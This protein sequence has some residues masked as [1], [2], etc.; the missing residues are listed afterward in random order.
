MAKELF[1]VS[2]CDYPGCKEAFI[3]EHGVGIAQDTSAVSFW[4]YVHGKGRKTNPVIVDMCDSH[5][6][7]QRELFVSLQKFNQK[8]Q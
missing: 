4:F 2:Y 6:E 7:S 1:V 8:E 5:A 3:K